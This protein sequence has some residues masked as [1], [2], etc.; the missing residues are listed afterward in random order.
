MDGA[1]PV[2][3]EDPVDVALPSTAPPVPTPAPVAL[4]AAVIVP[5]A[6]LP[7]VDVSVAPPSVVTVV[8]DEAGEVDAVLPPLGNNPPPVLVTAVSELAVLA[9]PPCGV[10][11]P[12]P[13]R[14]VVPP[15][16]AVVCTVAEAPADAPP[17][18]ATPAS[19]FAE[20]VASTQVSR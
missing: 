7:A 13:N 17:V 3:S 19:K 18:V 6:L 2:P 5:P 14:L 10:P 12:V 1:P 4:L 15:I 16:N 9:T 11:P 8:A 20:L